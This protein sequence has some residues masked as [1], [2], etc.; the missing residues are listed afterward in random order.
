MELITKRFAAPLRA[1][2]PVQDSTSKPLKVSFQAISFRLKFVTL[3]FFARKKGKPRQPPSVVGREG[4]E[5]EEFGRLREEDSVDDFFAGARWI[6][7]EYF[8]LISRQYSVLVV[9]NSS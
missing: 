2:S 5:F 8:L 7:R 4:S 9:K 3:D 1:S 6:V